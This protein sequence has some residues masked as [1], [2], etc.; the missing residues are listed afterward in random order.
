MSQLFGAEE[1]TRE[2]HSAPS[3]HSTGCRPAR[4]TSFDSTFLL[5]ARSSA[6]KTLPKHAA[7]PPNNGRTWPSH[8]AETTAWRIET[9]AG[10]LLTPRGS[11]GGLSKRRSASRPSV[12]EHC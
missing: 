5:I 7:S 4:S 10:T 2:Q 9:M 11:E 8:E 6:I 3:M 12:L 1:E